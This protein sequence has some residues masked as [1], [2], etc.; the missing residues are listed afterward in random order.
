M[1]PRFEFDVAGDI[2][3]VPGHLLGSPLGVVD[4]GALFGGRAR[5]TL[6]PRNR[7]VLVVVLAD[8][9]DL[10]KFRLFD[11]LLV[12]CQLLAL[13]KF[14]FSDV[15]V[16]GYACTLFIPILMLHETCLGL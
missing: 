16:Y 10:V 5:Q 6:D 9:W 13:E 7:E 4:Q 1:Y 11:D 12:E 15:A 14:H 2:V 8:A 3:Y